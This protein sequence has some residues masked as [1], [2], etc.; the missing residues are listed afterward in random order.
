VTAPTTT[1]A[2]DLPWLTRLDDRA[3]RVALHTPDGPLTYGDLAARVD[4]AAQQL[5]GERRLVQVEGRSA[6]QT[7]VA[8]LA[9]QAAGHVVLLSPAGRSSRALADAYAPDVVIDQSGR[10]DV[11]RESSA[12]VL[13]PRLALLLSTSG[14]TGSPK[15]VRL[16]AENLVA[17]TEQIVDALGVHPRDCAAMTLP[18]TYCYGLS[19]LTTHLAVG[20]SVMLTDTS[21]V[22]ECFW[23]AAEAAGVTTLPGV[24]HTFELLERSR[25]AERQLPT[26][27]CLTQAGGRM[28]PERVRQFAELG[29]RRGFDLHV[30][31]GQCEATAR[32]AALPPHLAASHPDTVGVPVGGSRVEIADGEVVFHGPNVMLGYADEPADLALGRVVHELRTGDLGE[33]TS[34]GL[35]RITG[36]RSRFVKVLGHRIDLDVLEQGLRADRYD[37][38]CSG[39]DGLLAVVARGRLSAVQQDRL[40]RAA[41]QR[42]GAPRDAVRVAAVEDLPMLANGKPDYPAVVALATGAVPAG[43]TAAGDTVASI[44]A[45]TLGAPVTPESTFVSLGGDSLS[46]VE[47]SIRLEQ[48]LGRLPDGWHVTPVSELARWEPSQ[49]DQRKTAAPQRTRRRW[50]MM[51]SS[52]WLRALSILL[53][54]GTHAKLFTLQGTANAL[55]VIAGYQL[56]RFQLA[57]DD[58]AQRSRRILRAAL[59]VAV[60]TLVVIAVA[61]VA[62]GDYQTRNLFLMNWAFGDAELGPPWRFWFVEALVVALVVVAVLCRLRPVAELDRRHPLG[63]PLALTGLAFV[64]FRVP[65]LS[66]PVPRMQGSA[67]VVMHLF[68]LGW[69]LA[70]TRTT[71]QRLLVS[72]VVVGL[73]G[74]FSWNQERDGLTIAVVL[75][76]V[77]FPVTMVPSLVVPLVRVLAAAS[78]YNYVIHW[79][80]LEVL[81]GHP[82]VAF[83]GSLSLGV[84]YWWVWSR[85]VTTGWQAL[86]R[87]L[88]LLPRGRG[89]SRAR[90]GYVASA[91]LPACRT[92]SRSSS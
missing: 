50:Q 70:R 41:C 8:L 59:R 83:L 49:R 32:M 27:R 91:T 77:W 75:V 80:A 64:L 89:R 90:G 30:M 10:V 19:V 47:A 16:S 21:V 78:L 9:A 20:A 24:P 81:W 67:L 45:H 28:D 29:Q 4:D 22:D 35:L 73:I 44:Y 68:L 65:W 25:F 82:V 57:P 33:V 85:P 66:L 53:I 1:P 2:L 92:T 46:Y 18:L 3:G 63:L 86:T 39:Q 88:R 54:V 71:G 42:T 14:S 34:D 6:P 74:T 58:R 5:A 84:A 12:H 38:R 79:Q 51:E 7:V 36:R 15:L 60:P 52:I 56:A 69:A 87:R 43:P 31:Y 62:L 37:V 17:N 40:H 23:R 13:H 76:M 61:H 26:L 11:R 72:A 55:L 48:L